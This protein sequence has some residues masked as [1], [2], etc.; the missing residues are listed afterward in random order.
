MLPHFLF[1]WRGLN[2]CARE[3]LEQSGNLGAC[4]VTFCVSHFCCAAALLPLL[5]QLWLPF[6]RRIRQLWST[7]IKMKAHERSVLTLRP[8]KLSTALRHLLVLL[9]GGCTTLLLFGMTS[10]HSFWDILLVTFSVC[11]A[12]LSFLWVQAG[13]DPF[14]FSLLS[15]SLF[16]SVVGLEGCLYSYVYK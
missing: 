4:D 1:Y 5:R 15:Q 14:S 13:T 11:S 3:R 7:L 12:F 9:T 2:V 8:V 10:A 16:V 6:W